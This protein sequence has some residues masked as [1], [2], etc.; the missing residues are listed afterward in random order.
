MFSN[1]TKAVVIA[2]VGFNSM[3]FAETAVT[4]SDAAVKAQAAKIAELQNR[5]Q[6]L[7]ADYAKLQEVTKLLNQAKREAGGYTVLMK[8]GEKTAT[9]GFGTATSMA[10]VRYGMTLIPST[11]LAINGLPSTWAFIK[12]A[13]G[14][15]LLGTIAEVEGSRQLSI[16]EGNMA[17]AQ[18][19][20]A[21]IK[22]NM[23][24][25][26]NAIATLSTG[27]G[28]EISAKIIDGLPEGLKM[29]NGGGQNLNVNRT[30]M[31]IDSN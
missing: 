9:W 6:T 30:G 20:I 8:A 15:F 11:R 7:N 2:M 1:I 10:F 3:A 14:M 21:Q 18:E 28:A 19:N 12:I 29:I 23:Q 5:V 16:S 26:R 22:L 4:H 24:A 25:E 27:L 13:G 31:I 17:E